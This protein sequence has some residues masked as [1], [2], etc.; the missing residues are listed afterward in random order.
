MKSW[1]FKS[2]PLAAFAVVLGLAPAHAGIEEVVEAPV[3]EAPE[4]AG[5]AVITQDGRIIGQ[6]FGWGDDEAF[7]MVNGVADNANQDETDVGFDM[8]FE[9]NFFGKTYDKIFV[10]TNG[11][12]TFEGATYSYGMSLANLIGT[13]CLD[14]YDEVCPEGGAVGIAAFAPDLYSPETDGRGVYFGQAV[15][16]SGNPA[17]VVTYYGQNKCCDNVT[18]DPQGSYFQMV[19]ESL[20]GG[21]FQA[22]FNYDYISEETA[23]AWTQTEYEEFGGDGDVG[24]PVAGFGKVTSIDADKDPYDDFDFVLES[25]IY[26][27]FMDKLMTEIA[28]TD[29]NIAAGTALSQLSLNSTV[30]GRFIL[31]MK[32]GVASAEELGKDRAFWSAVESCRLNM[33]AALSA[34][35]DVSVSAYQ[36]CFFTGVNASNVAAVNAALKALVAKAVASA[37]PLSHAELMQ[38]ASMM[39]D[40]LDLAQRLSTGKLVYAAEFKNLGL[41]ISTST[42]DRL[43]SL[44]SAEVDTWEEIE[45]AARR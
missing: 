29:E 10:N 33:A 2:I 34:G 39:A 5:S 35:S 20:G 1:L 6:Y 41:D 13:V 9:I 23:D 32:G 16:D 45:V 43:K 17:F 36:S 44:P 11:F 18:T 37:T 30:P 42:L 21:D 24:R 38:S 28:N 27:L 12:I 25:E 4:G 14:V 15:L 8:G 26:E 31:F 22:I 19:I 40:R 3:Y 7:A